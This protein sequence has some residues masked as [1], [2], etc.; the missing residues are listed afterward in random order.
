[1]H[2]PSGENVQIKTPFVTLA[3]VLTLPPNSRGV[4]LLSEEARH[5]RF[6]REL[7]EDGFATLVVD[8]PETSTLSGETETSVPLA[9]HVTAV[10]DWLAEQPATQRLRVGYAGSGESAGA[11]LAAAAERVERVGAVVS[12]GGLPNADADLLARVEAPVLLIAGGDDAGMVQQ[13]QEVLTLLR[14]KKQMEIVPD[15]FRIWDNDKALEAAV[16]LAVEWFR[17]Y[18]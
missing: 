13:N 12:C 10:T 15:V 2:Y 8:L 17:K 7:L 1:M 6:A 9:S 18:L 5:Q 4:V 3:G 16:R 11:L 14:S